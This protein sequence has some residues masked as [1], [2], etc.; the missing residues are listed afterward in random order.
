MSEQQVEDTA[1]VRTKELG[2]HSRSSPRSSGRPR[3]DVD[4]N[5]VKDASSVCLFRRK[6][7]VVCLQIMVYADKLKLRRIRTRIAQRTYRERKEH[8]LAQLKTRADNLN[9]ALGKVIDS[10]T[11]FHQRV[12]KS[13]TEDLPPCFTLE[14]GNTALEIAA[15]S[16]DALG[17]EQAPQDVPASRVE[18]EREPEHNSLPKEKDESQT[19][20]ANPIAKR[21][22]PQHSRPRSLKSVHHTPAPTR[23]LMLWPQAPSRENAGFVDQYL[24]ACLERSYRLYT[25]QNLPEDKILPAMTIPLNIESFERCLAMAREAL[26]VPKS[27][28]GDFFFYNTLAMSKLPKMYR[29]IEGQD[30]ALVPRLPPPYVQNLAYGRTRTRLATDLPLLQGEWLE[31][32]DVQEYLELQGISIPRVHSAQSLLPL[33]AKYLSMTPRHIED[34][35]SDALWNGNDPIARSTESINITSGFFDRPRVTHSRV[36]GPQMR[37]LDVNKFI[38]RIALYAV[39]LGPVPGLR[40]DHIDY[41][42][43]ESIVIE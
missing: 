34:T 19:E 13:G 32:A 6:A 11:R 22:K 30:T 8:E 14:L 33:P 15:T 5:T 31:A 18:S 21:A 26:S 16:R 12:V 1:V 3:M 28:L 42:V 27:H 10:F 24:R 25:F 20:P 35:T 39:C 43:V 37:Q 4:L 9:T 40:K 36:T 29:S 41:A 23:P 38:E 17:Q 2:R 7:V